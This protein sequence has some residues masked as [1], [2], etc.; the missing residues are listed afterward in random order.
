MD[1]N[2]WTHGF[3]RLVPPCLLAAQT[4]PTLGSRL[5]GNECGSLEMEL[6]SE[7]VEGVSWEAALFSPA[8]WLVS[9]E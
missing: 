2:G 3:I 8:L 1:G 9:S 6:P 5:D 7:V 4:D